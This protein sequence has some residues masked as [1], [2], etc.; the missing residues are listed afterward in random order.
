MIAAAVAAVLIAVIV[1]SARHPSPVRQSA[2][3]IARLT[4]DK[5]LV[6]E[7]SYSADGNTLAYSSDQGTE[8]GN[9][10]IWLD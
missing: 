10:S 9:L 3:K 5:G 6:Q 8:A 1:Y 7:I 4:F 2:E